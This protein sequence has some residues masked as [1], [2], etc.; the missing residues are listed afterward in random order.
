MRQ[1]PMFQ[2]EQA[3]GEIR[4]AFLKVHKQLD[5]G[6]YR[7]TIDL[8]GDI[9]NTGSVPLDTSGEDSFMRIEAAKPR[10]Q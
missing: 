8:A 5:L 6:N 4:C 1:Q 9:V 10:Q 3:P 2:G 7:P